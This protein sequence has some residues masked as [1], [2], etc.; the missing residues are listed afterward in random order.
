[1]PRFDAESL[2]AN[3]K[4]VLV[5]NLNLKLAAIE[6][7]KIAAGFPVTNLKSVDPD[8]GYFEQTWSDEIQNID[9]AI[10]YGIEEISAEGIGPATKEAF[11]IFVEIILIDSGQDSL[12]KNRIH[13]YA[14]AIKEV[15]E[16]NYDQVSSF[17]NKIKIETIRPTSLKLDLDTSETLKVG[18]VSITTA[19]A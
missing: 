16:E 7:E 9:P 13:R 5:T 2:M 8:K 19:I 14:R 17:G 15:F 10:F 6:A 18:G 1:M 11:K 12:T 3:V 4:S